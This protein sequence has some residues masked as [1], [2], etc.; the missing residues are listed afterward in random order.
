MQA[1]AVRSQ[2]HTAAKQQARTTKIELPALA[3]ALR[4]LSALRPD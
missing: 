1:F 3:S 2:S 4:T